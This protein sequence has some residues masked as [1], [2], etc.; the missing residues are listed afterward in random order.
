MKIA[1]RLAAILSRRQFMN[2]LKLSLNLSLLDLAE[3]DR[4][5]PMKI[6]ANPYRSETTLD[7]KLC[8]TYFAKMSPAEDGDKL[9]AVEAHGGVRRAA[10]GRQAG[11]VVRSARRVP[12]GRCRR[13]TTG[14][15]LRTVP[16]WLRAGIRHADDGGVSDLLQLVGRLR[17]RLGRDD[18]AGGVV[19]GRVDREGLV[20]DHFAAVVVSEMMK[21]RGGN[22]G[23][24][25]LV[26]VGWGFGGGR[27]RCR[28]GLTARLQTGLSSQVP[29]FK[30][31]NKANPAVI[32]VEL[33]YLYFYGFI[34][35]FLV[36][37]E[38]CNQTLVHLIYIIKKNVYY[39][40]L[41]HFRGSHVK[42]TVITTNLYKIKFWKSLLNKSED[43]FTKRGMIYKQ[44]CLVLHTHK[45]MKR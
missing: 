40:Y 31:L 33:F 27:W 34:D 14:Q 28:A 4:Q 3:L 38:F 8:G 15:A 22:G 13:L 12:I 25:R 37:G 30:F 6:N 24:L 21:R 32:I 20:G 26:V 7:K 16:P 35:R 23:G 17:R 43:Y 1:R 10:P 39:L 45:N 36:L 41:L 2:Y 42:I 5:N 29:D 9:E 44:I 18:D 19:V 11:P